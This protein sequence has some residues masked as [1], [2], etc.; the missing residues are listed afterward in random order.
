MFSDWHNPKNRRNKLRSSPRR[1]RR[2]VRRLHVEW[3]EDRRML[4]VMPFG[5]LPQDT[6]E[7][8]LGD[9]LVT[10]VLMES[11]EN[12]SLV[13]PNSEDWTFESIEAAKQKVVEGTQWWEQ[14]LAAQFPHNS[15]PLEFHYDFTYADSPVL[16][17]YEPIQLPSSYFQYWIYDFLEEVG[18]A[19]TRNFSQDIRRFNH[20]QRM[21][22]G[23]DWA[24]TV[25]VVNDE[26][27]EDGMFAG[28]PFLRAF[29]YAGGQFMVSPAGRPP[30]TFAHE[31]GHMFWARDEY[32]G[33]GNHGDRR[34]YYNAR[35]TNAW[36]NP[37]PDF[38]QVPSIMDRDHTNLNPPELLLTYA[39]QNLTTSP[40]SMA[41]IGWQDSSDNGIFD[42]LDVPHRLDGGGFLDPVQQAY[43][44]QG[45]SEVRTLTNRNSAGWQSDITINRIDVAE[46]RID[47]GAWFSVAEFDGRHRVELDLAIP[48][49]TTVAQ[50]IDIRTRDLRTGVTSEVFRARTDQWAAVQRPGINGVVWNDADGNGRFDPGERPLAD[51]TVRLVDAEGEP[52]D[53]SESLDPDAFPAGTS[54]GNEWAGV[55]LRTVPSA[56]SKRDV[57]VAEANS[58]PQL[59]HVLGFPGATGS[60]SHA[61]WTPQV[62]LRLDF[63]EP[64]S[65][66]RVDAVGF[67]GE[68]Y[69]RISVYDAA[70]RLLERTTSGAL[71]AGQSQTLAIERAVPEIASAIV[72]QH[73]DSHVLLDRLSIGP[74]TETVTDRG[75]DYRLG[76][77]PPGEYRVQAIAPPDAEPMTLTQVVTLGWGETLGSVDFAGQA[78]AVSWQN[79]ADPA[80]VTG[81]GQVSALDVLTVINYINTHPSAPRLP[82]LPEAPPP[83]YD[84][85]GNGFVTPNDA[86]IIINRLN[87]FS[88]ASRPADLPKGSHLIDVSGSDSAAAGDVLFAGEGEA[89]GGWLGGRLMNG[90]ALPVARP[91]IGRDRV[92]V[93]TPAARPADLAARDAVFGRLGINQAARG[94]EP[95]P[96]ENEYEDLLARRR[97]SDDLE[98]L[99]PLGDFPGASP[100]GAA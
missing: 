34:G 12:T 79:P 85:D 70:G 49:S 1:Y 80:D 3:L 84:V 87:S 5:A 35:N 95:E 4:A 75:G 41:M 9:V 56:G 99:A 78:S 63:S 30:S 81:D 51:W 31:T 11:S 32:Q 37:D 48:V 25:F 27:D 40:S 61:L 89:P 98:L 82:T 57:V 46:A 92:P 83:F 60:G 64:V 54:L 6:G 36:N 44:F 97:V 68:D 28:G 21:N 73:G 90:A 2:P 52:L 10:V 94:D 59:G 65:S 67:G 14:T 24:F 22:Y 86:L 39:Y 62:D 100:S 66:L 26:N 69:A 18:Y 8:M 38:V 29:A 43:R 76:G 33:G 55:Q 23:T 93:A 47:D 71:A 58:F 7:F 20:S 88:H 96:R 77:L 16:T 45:V 15:M 42:V 50:T 13:N 74:Q 19:D 72:G 91:G 17:D 53:L